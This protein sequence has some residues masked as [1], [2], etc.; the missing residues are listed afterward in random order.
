MA[1]LTASELMRH[2]STVPP[3]APV[4]F[5][6]TVTDGDWTEEETHDVDGVY[7]IQPE[8][9]A[10]PTGEVFLEHAIVR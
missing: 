2:L 7:A 5:H 9:S 3:D 8:D 6:V 10:S 1:A 4:R